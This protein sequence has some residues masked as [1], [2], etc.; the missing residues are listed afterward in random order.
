MNNF[1]SYTLGCVKGLL[2]SLFEYVN[3]GAKEFNVQKAATFTKNFT[4]HGIVEEILIDF[5]DKHGVWKYFNYGI[6]KDGKFGQ[7]MYPELKE[8]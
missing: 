2:E 4:R 1:E 7:V 5:K 8:G 3:D 6:D